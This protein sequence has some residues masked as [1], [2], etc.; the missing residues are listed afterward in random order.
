MKFVDKVND[1]TDVFINPL[2]TL[3]RVGALFACL[4]IGAGSVLSFSPAAATQLLSASRRITEIGVGFVV[5]LP[6]ARVVFVF[7]MLLRLDD[8]RLAIL[9]AYVLA[10][11][12]AT[13]ALAL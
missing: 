10:L 3:L 5:L 11:L 6:I 2:S 8:R 7:A 13:L 1:S 9:S 4:L 12:G